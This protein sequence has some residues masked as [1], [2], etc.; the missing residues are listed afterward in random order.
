[1]GG[2]SGSGT[3][4]A[5][6]LIGWGGAHPSSSRA[7]V[8]V[9]QGGPPPPCHR[10]IQ[11]RFG[12]SRTWKPGS[13]PNF[14]RFSACTCRWTTQ[15]N[16]CCPTHVAQGFD[17]DHSDGESRRRR[18]QKPGFLCGA[19]HGSLPV[20][21]QRVYHHPGWVRL[22]TETQRRACHLRREA[23]AEPHLGWRCGALAGSGRQCR[24]APFAGSICVSGRL[25]LGIVLVAGAV[26]ALAGPGGALWWRP[27]LAIACYGYEHDPLGQARWLCHRAKP[28][29]KL[30][31]PQGSQAQRWG[32]R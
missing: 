23:P 3:P 4:K 32:A 25:R 27:I 9:S 11:R 10:S 21:L 19:V 24:L 2:A 1:M 8:K 15:R 7:A 5:M 31:V 17:A 13:M 18:A 20:P 6:C 30:D 12:P 14:L 26:L 22:A 29:S 16:G 28:D